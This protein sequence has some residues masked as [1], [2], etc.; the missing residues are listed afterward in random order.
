MAAFAPSHL[1][2]IPITAQPSRRAVASSSRALSMGR[3]RHMT[4][5]ALSSFR[6]SMS[7]SASTLHP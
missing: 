3:S 4:I 2:P 5:R 7:A 6:R 1:A